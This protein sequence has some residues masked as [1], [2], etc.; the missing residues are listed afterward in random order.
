MKK[1]EKIVSALLTIALGV[2]LIILKGNVISILMTVLG[3]G[4]L[5]LGIV[6]LCNRLIPPAVVKL[7]SGALVILC[8]WVIVEA[9]LYLLAAALL[10]LGILVIYEKIKS[11]TVCE[12]LWQTVCEYAVPVVFILIGICLLFNQGNTVNWVFILSGVFTVV[13]G[14]LLLVNALYQD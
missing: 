5:A 7:V 13:E 6:E 8:G 9:V 3:L 4:L 1:T 10:I 14:G 12:A 11:K 2:L